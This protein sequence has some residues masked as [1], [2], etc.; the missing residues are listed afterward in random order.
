[1]RSLLTAIAATVLAIS[2][3]ATPAQAQLFLDRS[4][5]RVADRLVV[6]WFQQ[7]LGRLPTAAELNS[8]ATQVQTSADARGVEAEIL[9]SNEFYRRVGGTP[10]GYINGVYL[11]LL[12]RP[13]TPGDQAVLTPKLILN[14]RLWLAQYA[15]VTTKPAFTVSAP[16]VSGFV[17]VTPILPVLPI[18]P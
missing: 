16:I 13:A 6:G 17:P 5:Q 9:A 11:A 3:S 1:M 2:L 4:G 10:Q 8:F 15:L 18:V 14:G 12:G 7:Y